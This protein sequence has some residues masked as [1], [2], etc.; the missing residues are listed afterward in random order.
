MRRDNGPVP[1]PT[2]PSPG[3]LE[4]AQIVESTWAESTR[5]TYRG[6][7]AQVVA[8]C[9][10]NAVD[11]MPLEPTDLARHLRF[12]AQIARADGSP[13]A[14]TST[15]AL[16]VAAANAVH[17]I[18]GLP[19]PGGHPVV[20]A[21]MASIR[22]QRK[23]PPKQAA[24]FD[25]E[26]L[27]TTLNHFDFR[28]WPHSVAARR[29]AALLLLGFAGALR[30]SELVGLRTGDVSFEAGGAAESYLRVV[31]RA[32]KTDQFGDGEVI[33]IPVGQHPLTCVPCSVRAWLVLTSIEG[34]SQRMTATRDLSAVSNT[35][36]CD[37]PWPDSQADQPL[38]RRVYRSGAIGDG[39]LSGSSV[40]AVLE[41]RMS[42]AG[43]DPEPFS[44]HSLRA[45]FVTTAD[46]GG[47]LLTAIMR[48][49]R[50]RK[51]E[52]VVRYIRHANP[53]AGNAV[54]SVGL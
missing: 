45:G 29:D 2:R 3:Q 42:A 5:R 37:Q 24:A 39:A 1:T 44:A 22:R 32:S 35:H 11:A 7:W 27:R 34:R 30:R 23:R 21:A 36:H 48:Q 6:Q 20:V 54:K 25:V 14:A 38:L 40:G 12:S 47:A 46:A 18:A 33:A 53:M 49:T 8:W 28:H 41:R 26:M 13:A 17:R 16:R 19:E 15:L 10:R 50:H 31:I 51:P 4:L 52:T 9:D 43:M